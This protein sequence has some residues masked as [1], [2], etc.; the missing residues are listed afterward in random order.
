VTF[1]VLPSATVRRAL[2]VTGLDD[3]LQEP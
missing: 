2:E 3:V 1:H